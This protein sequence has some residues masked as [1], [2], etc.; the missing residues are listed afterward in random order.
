LRE[1]NYYEQLLFLD[2]QQRE[3]DSI[4]DQDYE[5]VIHGNW[6]R[7]ILLNTGYALVALSNN[8]YMPECTIAQAVYP[9]FFILE[10]DH[11]R[12]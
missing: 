7:G 12:P 5:V 11:A 4:R 8:A 3:G 6:Y 10:P 2:A 1:C 9:R